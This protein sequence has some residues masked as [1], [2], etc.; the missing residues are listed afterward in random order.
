MGSM[1]LMHACATISLLSN[2]LYLLIFWLL[3]YVGNVV[4]SL[5]F[6]WRCPLPL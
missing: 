6:V 4:S 5:S 3:V 1:Y 2:V